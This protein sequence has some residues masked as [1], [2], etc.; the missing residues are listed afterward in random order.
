MVIHHALDRLIGVLRAQDA[1]DLRLAQRGHPL[2]NGQRNT[3]LQLFFQVSFGLRH[4]AQTLRFIDGAAVGQLLDFLEPASVLCMVDHRL[5]RQL[6]AQLRRFLGSVLLGQLAG[7]LLVQH[8]KGKA[9][10]DAFSALLVRE[11]DLP[12]V[13]GSEPL[14]GPLVF[15]DD[16][17]ILGVSPGHL[18]IRVR[19]AGLLGR[20]HQ[21]RI[22]VQQ[23]RGLAYQSVDRHKILLVGGAVL[24]HALA[25]VDTLPDHVAQL[26]RI[27]LL[28]IPDRRYG[29]VA[30]GTHHVGEIIPAALAGIQFALSGQIRRVEGIAGHGVHLGGNALMEPGLAAQ[31]GGHGVDHA[32][33]HEIPFGNGSVHFHLPDVIALQSGKLIQRVSAAHELIVHHGLRAVDLLHVVQH[34][35]L[36]ALIFLRR[37]AELPEL[38]QA[39]AFLPLLLL[40]L[41]Q[42]L[43]G[44]VGVLLLLEDITAALFGLIQ[45]RFDA[46][47]FRLGGLELTDFLL[48]CAENAV[49]ESHP[50]RWAFRHGDRAV[51]NG[52]AG[53]ELALRHLHLDGVLLS[54]GKAED[55][56]LLDLLQ[57][58][59][60]HHRA[61]VQ[62]IHDLSVGRDLKQAQI[63]L[64]IPVESGLV[65][66][67]AHMIEQTFFD[68]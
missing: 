38:V 44:Q 8:L 19:H 50:E 7:D 52:P 3:L 27:S 16:L 60:G 40:A 33:C 39:A 55:A 62:G 56:A 49:G 53:L 22:P 30:G 66:I 43:L 36:L 14:G 10:V 11:L 48:I 47:T 13:G 1:E 26:L 58:L 45:R 54:G 12:R 57:K 51:L 68:L 18:Q 42:P 59:A 41:A 4:P 9:R 5:L 28:I 65:D 6:R 64:F 23:L 2:G 34:L 63:S 67:D 29:S 24:E 17:Q 25:H 20:F 61:A 31:L 35:F 21:L 37:A 46:L 15:V 32:H